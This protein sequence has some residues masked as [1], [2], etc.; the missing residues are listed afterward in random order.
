MDKDLLPKVLETMKR[1]LEPVEDF[2]DE[3]D[4][5]P[6]VFK[7]FPARL[8]AKPKA[9]SASSAAAGATAAKPEVTGFGS[10]RMCKLVSHHHKL[11]CNSGMQTEET[12]TASQAQRQMHQFT[13]TVTELCTGFET[14]KK[15]NEE[16]RKQV[17]Y[18]EDQIQKWKDQKASWDVKKKELERE[19]DEARKEALTAVGKKRDIEEKLEKAVKELNDAK[20]SAKKAI[21]EAVASTTRCYKNCVGNLVASLGNGEGESLKNGVKELIKEIL[22]DDRALA[23]EA[24]HVARHS[25]DDTTKDKAR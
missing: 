25:G 2:S 24:V 23:G 22:C 9:R 20:T 8:T 5:T 6:L 16:L 14:L 19:C 18:L 1:K 3:D 17:T 10:G 21:Y 15:K 12:T 7:R 4:S 11:E 13:S